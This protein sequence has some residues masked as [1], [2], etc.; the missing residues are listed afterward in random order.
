[1]WRRISHPNTV[2]FLGASEAPAPICMVAEWMPNGTVRNYVE[3]NPE[4]SRLQLV[5]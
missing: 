1:M 2:P 5:C 4:V 3:K